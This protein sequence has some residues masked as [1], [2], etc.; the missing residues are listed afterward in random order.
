MGTSLLWKTDAQLHDAVQYQLE[1]EP[2]INA[3]EIGVAASD[4]VV[5]LTGFVK[6]Y[7]EKLAAERAAK[8]VYGVQAVAN[9]LH[10]KLGDERT[11]SEIAK[12]ALHALQSHTGV[13]RDVRVTVRDGFLTLEGTLDWMYQKRAAESAVKY[14]KGVKGVSNQIHIRPPVS[15]GQVKAKIEEAL[16]R[17]AEVDARRICVEAEDSTVTLSGNVRS[18]AEKQEAERAAW[19]AP[20]VTKVESHIVVTP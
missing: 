19:A 20:G 12:D 1:W 8:R 3:R 17:S 7:A 10:V 5:T 16:R 9:D 6:T 2:E 15:T 14:R 11:D 13:P 4:G 18:W